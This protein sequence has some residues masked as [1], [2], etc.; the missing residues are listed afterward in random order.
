MS[1]RAQDAIGKCIWGCVWVLMLV[2]FP[3]ATIVSLLCLP[4]AFSCSVLFGSVQQ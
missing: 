3:F 4:F 2:L 1:D